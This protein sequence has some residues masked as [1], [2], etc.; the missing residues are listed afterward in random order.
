M[1]DL[2]LA[3]III[4]IL[5]VLFFLIW[6]WISKNRSR[7]CPAR[8]MWML[9]P[10]SGRSISTRT[11][12]TLNL[13]NLQAGMTILDA[14]CGPGRL[15]IPLAKAVGETGKVTALDLQEEMLEEVQER[16]RRSN[17]A[18]IT[19]L[20]GALGEGLLPENY[21]D[22]AVLITVLGEIADK[23]AAVTELHSSLKPGGI[24]LIE[25]TIRDPHYQKRDTVCNCIGEVGFT[26][27]AFFGNRFN[28]TLLFTK[29]IPSLHS[30]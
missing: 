26:Q 11:K 6:V 27:K 13:L 2:S 18:N 22:C 5:S 28:Y 21:F 29:A 30:E 3:L 8:L 12:K 25:E 16:A 24:L 17:C 15:T 19:Y 23:K 7:P 20:L 4:I 14:G 10:R 1:I 9:D